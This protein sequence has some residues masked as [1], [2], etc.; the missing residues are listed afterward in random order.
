[1]SAARWTAEEYVSQAQD[2]AAVS[3][4][5]NERMTELGIQQKQLA[6]QSGVSLAI[7]REVQHNV[8]QR[9]RSP[10]TLESLAMALDWHPQHLL[11]LL[12]G[13]RPPKPSEPRE[14]MDDPV[15]ARLAVIEDRLTDVTEQ[16]TALRAEVAA[17]LSRR[18]P[19]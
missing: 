16:L 15:T 10:R 17:A 18:E 6:A 2:W 7:V 8:V 5:I 1:M 14:D 11:A 4:A 9:R 13:R 19:R 3:K 12:H